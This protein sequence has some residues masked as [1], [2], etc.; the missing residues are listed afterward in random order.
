MNLVFGAYKKDKGVSIPCL[1]C[2]FILCPLMVC[3]LY[4]IINKT[5]QT[6]VT[7]KAT[8]VSFASANTTRMNARNASVK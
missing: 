8:R 2:Y 7:N 5:N 4:K 1:F 3:T 6:G